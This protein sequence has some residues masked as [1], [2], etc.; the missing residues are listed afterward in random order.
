LSLVLW[1]YLS[2]STTDSCGCFTAAEDIRGRRAPYLL[3]VMRVTIRNIIVLAHNVLVVVVVFAIFR[4]VPGLEALWC[5][6]AL[7]LW[8][9]DAVA[10]GVVLGALGA[11]FRDIPPIVG[12]VLQIA[13]FISPVIWKPNLI[14]H[15]EAW[16]GFN[17]FYTLLE[18]VR[19]P[20]LG[21]APSPLLWELACFYSALI[22][23]GA[24]WL[25]MRVRCRLAYWV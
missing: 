8:L 16:I 2:T 10:I 18:V 15:A 24:A 6:P 13:F 11:R 1:G 17:P 21:Q 4:V 9:V 12:S 20:L 7:L 19:G 14:P 25:F 3:H 22:C 23:G 5:L